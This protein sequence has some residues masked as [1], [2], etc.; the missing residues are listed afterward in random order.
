MPIRFS[1]HGVED[2]SDGCL[3]VPGPEAI[4]RELHQEVWIAPSDSELARRRYDVS[5]DLARAVSVGRFGDAD[6]LFFGAPEG[7]AGIFHPCPWGEGVEEEA[8]PE[9]AGALAIMLRDH[10]GRVGA[11]ALCEGVDPPHRFG[12]VTY[13]GIEGPE[14]RAAALCTAYVAAGWLP[15]SALALQAA[16]AGPLPDET[17]AAVKTAVRIA[18]DDLNERIGTAM[19]NAAEE[20]W[21]PSI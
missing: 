6:C 2:L 18:L 4:P 21:R 5:D 7:E 14:A 13:G 16:Q 9:I 8:L 10:A 3:R 12:F 17:P 1:L 20:T 11:I 19:R 15:P